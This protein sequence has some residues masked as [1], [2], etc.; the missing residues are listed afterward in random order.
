MK[1]IQVDNLYLKIF[2]TAAYFGIFNLF[3]KYVLSLTLYKIK[4]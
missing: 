1:I 4:E 2:F 3:E